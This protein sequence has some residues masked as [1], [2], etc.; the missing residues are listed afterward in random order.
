[1]QLACNRQPWLGDGGSKRL[2]VVVVLDGEHRRFADG[3]TRPSHQRPGALRPSLLRGQPR[4]LGILIM[5]ILTI[6]LMVIIIM[7]IIII[8]IIPSSSPLGR[9]G[10]SGDRW[11]LRVSPA[12][13]RCDQPR[14]DQT[15]CDQPR[16][17]P[18]PPSCQPTWRP[19]APHRPSGLGW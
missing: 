3:R 16:C 9:C 6:L 18:R 4:L 17:P 15:R 12:A 13:P 8:I 7:I 19:P 14:C 11:Q 1:M 2:D 10:R 5:I